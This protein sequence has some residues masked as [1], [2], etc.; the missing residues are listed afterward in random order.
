MIKEFVSYEMALELKEL[1]FDGP[2]FTYYYIDGELR[3]NISVDIHNGW[4]YFPNLKL[5][6]LAP[7]FSQAFRFFRDEKLSDSCVCRYQSR[8]DGGIY[9]YYVINHDFGIKET[10]HFKEGFFSYEEA[11]LACLLKLIKIVKNKS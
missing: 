2:C 8:D 11:E 10:K 3:K 6:T 5:I 7:T 4:T 9:Y 1:G